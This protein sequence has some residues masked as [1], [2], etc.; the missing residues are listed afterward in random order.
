MLDTVDLIFR[1]GVDWKAFIAALKQVQVQHQDTPLHIQS[2]ENKGDGVVVVK[3]HVPPE[4]DKE[5][6]HQDFNQNYQLALAAVEAQYK[7]QL[8][9]KDE[10]IAD[11]RQKYSE[12]QEIT[13]LLASR[14]INV[15]AT[16]MNHSTDSSKTIKA[17]ND[18]NITD[19]VRKRQKQP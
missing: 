8:A 18:V 6:I 3:V 9:A 12:M 19:S 5:Q 15:E 13:K 4:A 16:V 1:N 17:G 11:H 10:V 14:P 2:I 7:A